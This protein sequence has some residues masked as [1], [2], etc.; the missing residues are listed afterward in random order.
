MPRA[1]NLEDA[2]TRMLWSSSGRTRPEHSGQDV[3]KIFSPLLAGIEQPF[4]VQVQD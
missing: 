4:T 1:E 2:F 3:V